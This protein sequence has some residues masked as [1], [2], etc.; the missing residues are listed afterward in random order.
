M[1]QHFLLSKEARSF[2]LV[3][4]AQLTEKQAENFFRKI[5]WSET[6]GKPICPCCGST[7]K[8]YFLNTRKKW[9][10]RDCYKQFTITSGTLFSSHK[11][12]LKT[13]LMAIA[14]FVNEVKGMSALKL[15]REL[16]IQYKTAFVLLHKFRDALLETR[17]E[18][19]LNGVC[20]IDGAYVNHYVRPENNINDRIDRR[21]TANQNP[22]KRC[23]VVVRQRANQGTEYIGSVRTLTYVLHNENPRDIM[24]IANNRIE[25]G[26]EVHADEA[27]AYDNLHARFDMRRVNHSV[28]YMSEQGAC[29][30]QAESFF[31]RF[32]RFQHGQIHRMGQLYISNYAN[33]IAYREDT[34]RMDNGSIFR[35]ITSKCMKTLQSNEWTGY[36]QGNHRISERLGVA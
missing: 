11:L 1:A 19:P 25:L 36:W 30:N 26:T 9:K 8:H 21:L 29:S 28:E 31:A 5:R 15:S 23:I 14:L 27:N 6:N 7:K 33:E 20:E 17:D 4:I 13:Y 12:P 35:D 10:C 22:N 16:D 2:S 18:T 3:K 24:N 34:R 32:R